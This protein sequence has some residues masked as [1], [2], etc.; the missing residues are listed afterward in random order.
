MVWVVGLVSGDEIKRLQS[1]GWELET[2]SDMLAELE[3]L[4]RPGK[5][6][7]GDDEL[8]MRCCWVD[9]SMSDVMTGPSWETGY[10][11]LVGDRGVTAPDLS[12]LQ[13]RIRK[14]NGQNSGWIRSL[15][16]LLTMVVTGA[17]PVSVTGLSEPIFQLACQALLIVI[18]D[19]IKADVNPESAPRSEP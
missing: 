6:M 3:R 16:E 17:R 10:Q 5:P 4:D 2:T 11:E 8:A 19:A 7:S 12:E 9:S 15:Q 1:L 18:R 14:L 13:D